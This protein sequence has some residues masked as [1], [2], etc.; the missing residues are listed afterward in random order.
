[1]MAQKA[2]KEENKSAVTKVSAGTT[3][4]VNSYLGRSSYYNG[5]IS[6]RVFDSLLR[7]GVTARDSFGNNFKVDGF[8][9]SYAERNLYEDSVGNLITLTDF[10][11]EF[12]S[13]DTLS[14]GLSL[15]I[16]E[17]TKPGDT[18]YFD[19]IK[20]ISPGS[21]AVTKPMRFIITR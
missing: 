20:I 13:G 3:K 14:R 12:C 10:I 6:K 7:Q 21:N 19:N 15:N 2:K 11:S 5:T 16:Y 8:T 4:I 17:K 1:M 18:A 9:F